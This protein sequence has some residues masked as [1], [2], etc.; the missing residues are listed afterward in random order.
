VSTRVNDTKWEAVNGILFHENKLHV[1][2]GGNKLHSV[3]P[4][5][6][7]S[8]VINIDGS[9]GDAEKEKA[10]ASTGTAGIVVFEGSAFALRGSGL[11]QINLKDGMSS[12]LHVKD[13]EDAR[14]LAEWQGSFYALC[15]TSLCRVDPRTGVKSTVTTDDGAS[16]GE[17]GET[18]G[19]A[20]GW[21]AAKTMCVQGGYA[22][23]PSSSGIHRIKLQDGSHSVPHG[24]DWDEVGY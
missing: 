16:S 3:D 5:T 23:C 18:G 17:A 7:Q 12:M 1:L 8:T 13:F 6:G 24:G 11:H 4:V 9:T 14:G 22:Y 15:G 10:A 2:C 21:G 20:A 19:Q